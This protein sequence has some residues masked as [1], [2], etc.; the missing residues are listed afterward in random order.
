[1]N[2][3]GWVDAGVIL[4]TQNGGTGHFFELALVINQN[5]VP[6]NI[7]T[8]SL[9]DRIVIQSGYV[10]DGVITL[11]MLTHGPSD[12]LCCAN[13]QEVRKYRLDGN[14]LILIP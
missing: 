11:V 2:F 4:V 13:Q 5:G 8:V 10:Q 9:G 1:M 14:Q 3:D 7:S 12:P 6:Y